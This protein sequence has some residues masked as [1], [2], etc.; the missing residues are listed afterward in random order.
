MRINYLYV[1]KLFNNQDI[2]VLKNRTHRPPT[3]PIKSKAFSPP[4]TRPLAMLPPNCRPPISLPYW[5]DVS[6]NSAT[7]CPTR[8]CT[9][10]T[11]WVSILFSLYRCVALLTTPFQFFVHRRH[12]PLL[13]DAR[14]YHIAAG[15][16]AHDGPAQESAHPARLRPLHWRQ[17]WSVRRQDRIP[18]E[19]H[20]GHRS[21]VSQEVL[22][23][24]G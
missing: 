8:S 21:Q 11:H 1:Q 20:T 3:L 23:S 14:Q 17:G 22:G 15:R 5:T 7:V 13:W 12:H 6:S 9:R 16:D 24:G 18:A 4:A 10:L 19:L 2:C